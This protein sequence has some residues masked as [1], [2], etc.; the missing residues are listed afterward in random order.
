ML[1]LTSTKMDTG[2]IPP[3]DDDPWLDALSSNI[4]QESLNANNAPNGTFCGNAYVPGMWCCL[5]HS[6]S[7]SNPLAE[8]FFVSPAAA[9]VAAD[10]G[11][12]GGG[13]KAPPD[14]ACGAGGAGGADG[15]G[16]AV[17]ALPLPA[18]LVIRP[19]NSKSCIFLTS[20]SYSFL[21]RS[22]RCFFKLLIS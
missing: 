15:A 14:D 5:P 16:G 11:G 8:L 17:D 3:L 6:P 22:V 18:V 9:D 21:R 12:G 20:E 13:A 10:A 1:P 19:I 4:L 7:L 2:T